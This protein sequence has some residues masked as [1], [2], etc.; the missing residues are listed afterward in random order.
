MFVQ[1]AVDVVKLPVETVVR[2]TTLGYPSQRVIE[3]VTLVEP[4]KRWVSVKLLANVEVPTMA[5]AHP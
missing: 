3:D 1:A 4:S 2:P 5:S